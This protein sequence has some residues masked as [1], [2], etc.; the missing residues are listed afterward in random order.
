MKNFKA[1]SLIVVLVMALS[2]FSF[3]AFAQETSDSTTDTTVTDP[4][5][6][7]KPTDPTEPVDPDAPVVSGDWTY[8]VLADSTLEL[9]S[10]SGKAAKV[11]IPDK[12]DNKVVTSVASGVVKNNA[13]IM[14]VEI[15]GSITSFKADSFMGC[16]N[17]K[18][19]TVKSGKLQ[20]FDIEYCQSIEVISLPETVKTIG[21]FEECSMLQ[22]IDI[23]AKNAS[24]RSIDGVVY[25]A[26]AK[27]LI[28]YPAGK[29]A[30]RFAIPATV[31]SVSDYAFAATKGNIK[32]IFIPSSV[33]KMG[34]K[35]FDTCYSKLLFQA[36]KIPAG[37]ENA[38]KGKNTLTN[39]INVYAP[40]KITDY[41]EAATAVS[42]QWAK[43]AGAH[44]YGVFVR[45]G[46]KWKALGTTTG[47]IAVVKNLK[48]GTKYTFAVV[49]L[50]KTAAGKVE[51]SPNYLSYQTSTAPVATSKIATAQN[52]VAIKIAWAK[53][54]GADGY[55][56]YL[57]T[58]KGWQHLANTAGTSATI[59]NLKPYTSYTFAVRSIT[60]LTGRYVFGGYKAVTAKT[61][62]GIPAPSVTKSGASEVTLTWS[63]SI[64]ASHYQVFYKV[65]D[66][67]W[68]HAGTY[69]EI[70][71]VKFPGLTKGMK[72]SLAVRGV[73]VENGKVVA[74]S[75]YKPVTVTVK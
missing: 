33:V 32:E 28:K 48:A 42:F 34:D 19:V 9:I 58:A 68:V 7:T 2:L 11:V 35:A 24:L 41:K 43:V 54:A 63:P 57:K 3:S 61:N 73:R 27:T 50:V 75:E 62:L 23:A 38:V 45:E 6:T 4:S 37:C 46:N 72:L 22:R 60:R 20:H 70:A 14:S 74:K 25:S 71:K 10:Y 36:A 15:P 55:A 39:Q 17:L 47:N 49:S 5:D 65:N 18:S 40:T 30:N 53:V 29:L 59:K 51:K 67:A 13:D 21:R 64:G 1:L 44:G 56:I 12:L 16:L 66:G 8:K 69:G 26:D 31:T 52:D